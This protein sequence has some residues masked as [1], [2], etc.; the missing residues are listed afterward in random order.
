MHRLARALVLLSFGSIVYL[1][2]FATV[3]GVRP[4]E[5]ENRAVTPWPD[6]GVTDAANASTY[7]DVG[8]YLVDRFPLRSFGIRLDARLNNMVWRDDTD[9]VVRGNDGWLFVRESFTQLCREALNATE[10]VEQLERMLADVD[11]GTI[12]VTVV[13]SKPVVHPGRVPARVSDD[14]QARCVENERANM[15]REMS[16][17]PWYVDLY[18]PLIAAGEIDEVFY[19]QDTHWNSVGALTATRTL[20]DEL[21]PTLWESVTIRS[22]EHSY[23]PDL[24]LMA[25]LSIETTVIQQTLERAGVQSTASS[26]VPPDSHGQEVAPLRRFTSSGPALLSGKTVIVHDSFLMIN[27]VYQHYIPFFRDVT[28]VHWDHVGRP[29]VDELIATADRLIVEIAERKFT[30]RAVA[31]MSRFGLGSATD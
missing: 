16:L 6:V 3:A 13:P 5:L 18:A 24:A 7:D 26:D 22:S 20:I 23:E 15:R 27:D 4:A 11:A 21:D 30:A 2:L 9:R 14:P 12:L 29:E 28:F 31:H 25:G 10:S 1:P 8:D 19:P 17:R